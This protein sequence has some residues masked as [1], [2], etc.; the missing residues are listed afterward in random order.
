MMATQREI[1]AEAARPM[2]YFPHDVASAHDMKL[3]LVIDEFGMAGYGRW[4]RLLELLAAETGHK[5]EVGDERVAKIVAR[6]LSTNAGDLLKF[7]AFL[8]DI[9]LICMPGDGF[10]W[11]ERMIEQAE[12]VGEKRANGKRGGRP[13]KNG[14]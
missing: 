3:E 8:A 14:S 1:E 4:W 6:R 11:S 7:I 10:I 2:D 5:L 13:K 12:R 9:D